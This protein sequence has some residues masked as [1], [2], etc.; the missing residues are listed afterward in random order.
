MCRAPDQT[1][2]D[3]F[4]CTR[5]WPVSLGFRGPRFDSRLAFGPLQREG[6]KEGKWELANI[7]LL[8]SLRVASDSVWGQA[9]RGRGTSYMRPECLRTNGAP[10]GRRGG[11]GFTSELHGAHY[12]KQGEASLGGGGID[13]STTDH[14]SPLR[15]LPCLSLA[16]LGGS[17]ALSTCAGPIRVGAWVREGYATARF[18]RGN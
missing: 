15:P 12:G 8:L 10:R 3:A 7:F 9:H 6:E 16:C 17:P 4:P 5:P 14:V 1:V 18:W 13:N 11:E 2:L